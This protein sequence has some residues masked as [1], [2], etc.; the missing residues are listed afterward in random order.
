MSRFLH[1]VVAVPT[2]ESE[3]TG[4]QRMAVRDRLLRLIADSDRFWRHTVDGENH[5]VDRRARYEQAEPLLKSFCPFRKL[6]TTH[7]F[8][9]HEV[10]GELIGSC[11]ATGEQ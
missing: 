6:E 11:R 3:S 4:V 5:E 2:I 9:P 10:E 1:G 7:R 8:R